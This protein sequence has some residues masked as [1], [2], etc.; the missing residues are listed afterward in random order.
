MAMAGTVTIP[1]GETI[2]ASAQLTPYYQV[3]VGL[4]APPTRPPIV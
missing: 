2:E 1:A 3:G 4:A